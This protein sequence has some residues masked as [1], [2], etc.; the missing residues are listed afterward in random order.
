M[1]AMM[2]RAIDQETA[3][4]GGAHFSDCDLCGRGNGIAHSS[5]PGEGMQW[6]GL[7]A[8]GVTLPYAMSLSFGAILLLR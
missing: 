6:A 7:R 2:A 4:A 1:A 3:H 8:P 5:A